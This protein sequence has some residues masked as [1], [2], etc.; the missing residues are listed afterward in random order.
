MVS[1]FK[2][3]VLSVAML[4]CA[5]GM[6]A[7]D[8]KES[9]S[10][11]SAGA[12]ALATAATATGVGLTLFSAKDIL[13]AFATAKLTPDMGFGTAGQ[14]I[15]SAMSP[16]SALLIPGLLLGIGAPLYLFKS[17]RGVL[18][19]ARSVFGSSMTVV[20][21]TILSIAL[22]CLYAAMTVQEGLTITQEKLTQT[23][24]K[25]EAEYIALLKATGF[26]VTGC[27]TLAGS[28]A[29]LSG[30]VFQPVDNGE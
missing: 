27:F 6:Q 8:K 23:N 13:F 26:I 20:G 3:T 25:S 17:A 19:K 5:F 9:N 21:G 4:G 22:V 18:A 15:I 24:C 14:A 7:E 28:V 11:A 16:Q 12:V 2:K 30:Y 1:L 10:T 29:T